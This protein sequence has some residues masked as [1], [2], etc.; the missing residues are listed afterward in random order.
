MRAYYTSDQMLSIVQRLQR[1]YEFLEDCLHMME[2]HT[3]EW[4]QVEADMIAVMRDLREWE[5]RLG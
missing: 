2:A 4:Y 1:Q 3:D 5:D